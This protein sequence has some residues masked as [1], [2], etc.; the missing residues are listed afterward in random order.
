MV[1]ASLALLASLVN[2]SHRCSVAN[3]PL[4]PFICPSASNLLFSCLVAPPGLCLALI[5]GNIQGLL[6]GSLYFS[7]KQ[8]C[9]V[10][11]YLQFPWLEW[12]Q[13]WF[14]ICL[15]ISVASTS[16]TPLLKDNK[17]ARPA[18]YNEQISSYYM[19]LFVTDFI[20]ITCGLYLYRNY[21]FSF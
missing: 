2:H 8:I 5:F 7:Q 13:G 3:K 1:L 11:H 21:R 14:L 6:I 20:K 12:Q 10:D 15:S 19:E 16:Q 17:Y 4:G 9:V 18:N